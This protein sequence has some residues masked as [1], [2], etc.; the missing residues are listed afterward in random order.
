MVSHSHT[1]FVRFFI[2][3]IT[4]KQGRR[5]ME[6]PMSYEG[7]PDILPSG[8]YR[9]NLTTYSFIDGKKRNLVLTQYLGALKTTTAE[10]WK[11]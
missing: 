5:Y 10:Q 3:L 4:Y 9:L 6:Q 1:I 11:K 8:E 7:L 2:E